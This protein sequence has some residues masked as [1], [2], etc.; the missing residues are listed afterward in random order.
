MARKRVDR[1]SKNL[2]DLPNVGRSVA[3]DLRSIG[4]ATPADLRDC[5]AFELY[6]KIAQVT[7][8]RH[9]PCLLDTFM[10]AIDFVNGNPARPWWHYTTQRK[11]EMARR[12]NM[13]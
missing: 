8:Q 6:E 2:E 4:I 5:D 1:S 3:E 12:A 10:S 9:D 11:T 7:G 13:S